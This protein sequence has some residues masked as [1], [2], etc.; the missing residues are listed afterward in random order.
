MRFKKKKLEKIIGV[1]SRNMALK[2]NFSISMPA[3]S[4]KKAVVKLRV[5]L[6]PAYMARLSL[7]VI[8]SRMPSIEILPAETTNP[9][10]KKTHW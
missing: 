9:E 1:T 6:I 7:V 4:G 3:K 5:P 8:S 10:I 2:P